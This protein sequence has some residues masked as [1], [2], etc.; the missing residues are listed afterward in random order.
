MRTPRPD[1]NNPSSYDPGYDLELDWPTIEASLNMQYGI[2]I[3]E[4]R[5]MPFDEFTT[6]LSGLMPDTPLGNLVQIRKETDRKVIAKMT[7]GQRKIRSDWS[8]FR[9]KKATRDGV[10]MQKQAEYLERLF[11]SISKRKEAD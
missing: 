8:A 9:A 2:R 3:R 11:A 1:F 5:N 10:Q 4:L 6:L 7:A